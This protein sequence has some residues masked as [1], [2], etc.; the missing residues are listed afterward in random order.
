[1]AELLHHLPLIA[2]LL[3]LEALLG[4][5]F[6]RL[7][8]RFRARLRG[9]DLVL[10]AAVT[11]AVLAPFLV[12]SALLVP[13]ATLAEQ[14]PGA[15]VEG[16]V[17]PY[18]RGLNDAVLQFFPWEAEVRRA[19][20]A[21][22]LPLWSD[23][24]DGGSGLWGN[25]QAQ[26]LSPLALLARLA[27][28]HHFLLVGLALKQLTALAGALALLAR[29]GVRRGPAWLGALAFA[30][31]GGFAPWAVFPHSAALPWVP[32]VV[33]GA[34]HLARRRDR[35]ALL[36]V[37]LLTAALLLGG[38]PEIAAAGCGLAGLVA[39]SLRSRRIAW[40]LS[41][42]AWGTTLALGFALAAPQW[43][44][45]FHLAAGSERGAEQVRAAGLAG[46]DGTGPL[47]FE[48]RGEVLLLGLLHPSPAPDGSPEGAPPPGSRPLWSHQ[49]SAYVGL[50]GFAGLALLLVAPPPRRSWPFLAVGLYTLLA[51]ADFAPVARATRALPVLRLVEDSRFMPVGTLALAVAAA[52][53]L[54]TLRR[55]AGRLRRA[56][57]LGGAAAA[58]LLAGP[59]GAVLAGWTGIALGAGLARR[60]AAALLL[61]GVALLDLVAWDWRLLPRGERAH[62]YPRTA[63]VERLAAERDE[64][65][66]TR[67][68]G[69]DL[70][71]YPSLLAAYGLDEARPY[72][73]L[74]PQRQVETL[75][76]AFDYRRQ[77]DHYFSPLGGIEHP[78]L[79]F[80]AVSAVV[81]NAYLPRP[82]GFV[83]I[84]AGEALPQPF[85]LLRN[86]GALP[87]WFL[88]SGADAVPP[89]GLA[90]WIAGMTDPRRVALG[91]EAA[92][93]LPPA[94]AGGEVRRTGG[95]PGRIELEVATGGPALLATSIPGPAGW[96][97]RADGARLAPLAVNGAYLGALLPA[98]ARRVELRYVPR[99][100]A[101]GSALALAA[102]LLLLLDW[103]RLRRRARDGQRDGR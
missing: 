31:G 18:D 1:M 37:T 100:L 70:L 102:I 23:A 15:P 77:V 40:H 46:R 83:R 69:H 17:D 63:F 32:W 72:N 14:V 65:R 53:G 68:T 45:L 7:A 51:L 99:G 50:V 87:R 54:A 86:P 29:L 26:V 38:H 13:T 73:P 85:E 84:D 74:A 42:A 57:G 28:L 59:P 41:L 47:G 16:P 88:A 4:L 80:L 19:F 34:L 89:G 56:A 103:R 44:P 11:L 64:A 78:F 9:R 81:S 35:R 67:I 66:G 62:F 49:M 2:A 61:A 97:V 3:G 75:A 30:L 90:A 91:P 92:G 96:R 33:L 98:G 36:P 82:E 6:L 101:T 21:G 43:L 60:R 95:R 12:S 48:G 10:A 79:D 20:A 8:R 94:L 76:A 55:R 24:L 58:S 39:L 71:V 25:P 93:A 22:R 5:L 52:L 27:P